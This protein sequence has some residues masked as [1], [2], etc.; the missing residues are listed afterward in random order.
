MSKTEQD[1]NLAKQGHQKAFNNL[2]E[3]HWTY[4]YNYIQSKTDNTYTSEELCIQTF[5]RAFDKIDQYDDKYSFRTWLITI[6]KR[7]WIDMQRKKEI[8]TTDINNKVSAIKSNEVNIED[9]LIQDQYIETIESAIKKLKP[10]DQE[11]L[12][13]RLFEDTPYSEIANEMSESVNLIKVKFFRAKRK[14]S[15]LIQADV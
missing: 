4:V 15:K 5:A 14:L 13:K 9:Q 12:K 2:L 11:I 6:C 7:L 10:N 3:Q 8:K 1:I